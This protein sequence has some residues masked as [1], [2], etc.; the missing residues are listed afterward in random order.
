M[1]IPRNACF[2]SPASAKGAITVASSNKLDVLSY[3]SN[4]GQCISITAPGEDIRSACKSHDLA[5]INSIAIN[6]S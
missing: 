1:R 4:Y 2:D 3:F 6:E 5:S